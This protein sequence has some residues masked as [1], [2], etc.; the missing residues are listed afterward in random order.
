MQAPGKQNLSCKAYQLDFSFSVCQKP[1]MLILLL[2][3]DANSREMFHLSHA[4]T[5]LPWQNK[6]CLFSLLLHFL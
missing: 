4:C 5:E 1:N 6:M 3:P 2:K